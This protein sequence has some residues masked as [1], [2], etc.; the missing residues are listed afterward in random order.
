MEPA[1]QKEC[2][3]TANSANWHPNSIDDSFWGSSHW[4]GRQPTSSIHPFHRNSPLTCH[5]TNVHD[6]NDNRATQGL[7]A[8]SPIRPRKC[9]ASTRFYFLSSPSSPVKFTGTVIGNETV[10]IHPFRCENV[11]AGTVA[12]SRVSW[13]TELPKLVSASQRVAR[14]KRIT[15]VDEDGLVIARRTTGAQGEG[16]I[17]DNESMNEFFSGSWDLWRGG[18]GGNQRY[19]SKLGRCPSDESVIDF[20]VA[21]TFQRSGARRCR[22]TGPGF[23]AVPPHACLADL[24]P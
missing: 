17:V 9:A 24:E 18:G 14:C 20:N 15:S 16:C 2:D 1:S 13:S 19:L 10:A 7:L 5:R 23:D 21:M 3:C 22:H 12:A 6:N 4:L 8:P 11:A